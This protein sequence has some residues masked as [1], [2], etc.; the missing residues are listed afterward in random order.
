VVALAF[1]WATVQGGVVLSQAD[2]VPLIIT[3]IHHLF[4][5]RDLLVDRV[6]GMAYEPSWLG[7][8]LMVLYLPLL[9]A[10]AVTRQSVFPF[11]RGWLSIE[12]VMLAWALLILALTQSRISQISFLV[13]ACVAILVLGWNVLSALQRRLGWTHGG[14]WGRGAALTAVNHL[15]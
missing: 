13:L 6:S 9:A 12:A 11:R 1:V 3:R 7:N 10:G 8:Q 4:S 2:H 14:R 15:S 5:V